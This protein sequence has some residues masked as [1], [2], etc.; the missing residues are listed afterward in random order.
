MYCITTATVT[1]KVS[2]NTEFEL[3]KDITVKLEA[4]NAKSATYSVNDGKAVAYK[5]GDSVKI[6]AK[7]ADDSGV[8]TLTL[9]AKG[10]AGQN[11]YMKYYF[12]K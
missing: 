12:T 5:N 4:V 3:Y 2:D 9:K 1:V 11:S 8:V 10:E 7:D 6:K